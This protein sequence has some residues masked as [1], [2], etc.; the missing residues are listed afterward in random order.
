MSIRM[1]T[2]DGLEE[3]YAGAVL[4]TWEVNGYN[5]SDWFAAVWD[6]AEQ[7]VRSVEWATTRGWT[8][9]NSATVDATPEV[10]GKAEAWLADTIERLL[11]RADEQEAANPTVG[12]EVR[13]TTTRGK[14]KGVVGLVRRRMANPYRTYYRNGYNDPESLSN[15]R[16]AVEVIGEDSYRWLDADRVEVINP[17]Q[18]RMSAETIR[19]RAQALAKH[20][21]FMAAF[22]G[23]AVI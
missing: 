15:Q 9:D 11:T 3:T 16:L 13:S 17:Q 10:P 23:G 7:R 12:K 1:D 2:R 18:Y 8:L 4:Q 14:N 5:D 20:R 22:W 21:N 19:R 6:E